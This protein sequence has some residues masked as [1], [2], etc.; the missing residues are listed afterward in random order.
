MKSPYVLTVGE[1]M[2][3]DTAKFTLPPEFS[4]QNHLIIN[5]P[6]TLDFNSPGAQGF[7]VKRA[8]L[9]VPGSIMLLVAPGCC[10]RNTAAL[11]G[12]N[13]LRERFAYLLLDD[14]DI[15]TGRH[16]AKIDEAARLFIA[17]RR[18]AP[19]VLMICITCVDALL[20]TDMDSLCRRVEKNIGLPVRPCYMYALTRESHRPPMTAIRE[21][22]YSLLTPGRRQNSAVNLLGFFAPLDDES[23]L[24]ALLRQAGVRHIRELARARDYAA[25]QDLARANFNLVLNAEARGAAA[26]FRRQLNIPSLELTRMYQTDK[27]HTQ[28]RILAATLNVGWNDST[29]LCRAQKAVNGF[30]RAHQG[31]KISLGSRLNANPFE[32]ALA[33]TRYGLHV[34]EILCA[35]GSQDFFYLKK[36]AEL[37][38]HTKIYN[39]LAPIMLDFPTDAPVDLAIGKDAAYYHPEAA[40]VYWHDEIQ[41]FGYSAVQKLFTA[42][43]KA[44]EGKI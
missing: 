32:L 24:Y 9:A 26:W 37:S 42:M 10:G 7:G 12:D 35:P 11:A 23:E 14:K 8:G 13:D 43:G 3:Q 25:Y 19:T 44:W 27:I 22:V 31:I 18:E 30:C 39:H 36:L 41:P 1:L 28:Y 6:A 34:Q 29:Y 4:P 33:M 20:G 21:T 17:S 40:A 5:T 15:I 38:P 16:L 2:R